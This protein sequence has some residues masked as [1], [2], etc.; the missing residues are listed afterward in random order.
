VC[1]KPWDEVLNMTE[2]EVDRA[3][4]EYGYIPEL[5]EIKAMELRDK[6]LEE[7]DE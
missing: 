2:E 4:M 5:V 3:L 7:E 6:L 1:G